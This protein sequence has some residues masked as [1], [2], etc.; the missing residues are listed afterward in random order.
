MKHYDLSTSTKWASLSAGNHQVTIVA[1]A[2]GYANSAPSAAVTVVKPQDVFNITNVL[3]NVTADGENPTTIAANDSVTLIYTANSG[4]TLPASVTVT[5]ATYTWE[6]STGV[7]DISN[8]TQNVTIT[9]AGVKSV[10]YTVT[11][12]NGGT[13]SIDVYQSDSE[14]TLGDIVTATNGVYVISKP[15]ITL[16]TDGSMIEHISHSAN[17]EELSGDSYKINGDG[18]ISVNAIC[19]TGDTLITLAD[20]SQKRIDE[21]TTADK[22][23]SINPETNELEADEII[24]CDSAENKTHTEYDIYTLSDGT[25]IKT[26]HRHRFYNMERQAMVYMDEWNIGEHFIK[27]DGSS[28]ALVSHEKVIE[29]VKH[30]T[31]FTKKNQNY[32]ANGALSGNRFTKKITIKGD[33]QDEID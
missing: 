25:E 22:V 32:F 3:S 26:V 24:Y 2:Q 21:I 28:P 30:Y 8:P 1:K 14:S 20:G 18:S 10:S 16:T 9:I 5:G 13:N 11:I 6:Q 27:I 7:L 4:Y 29:T 23:L 15:Y 12:N 31:I 17:I 33:S 19:L